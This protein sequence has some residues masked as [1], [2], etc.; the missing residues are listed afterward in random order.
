[1]ADK[2]PSTTPRIAISFG[3]GSAGSNTAKNTNTSK[4]KPPSSLGKRSRSSALGH[5]SDS[6]SDDGFHRNGRHE[7]ITEFG[8]DKPEK[9][10]A[11]ELVIDKQQNRDWKSELRAKRGG[12]KNLLP[13]EVQAQRRGEDI[14]AKTEPADSEN[15]IQWGLSVRKRKPSEEAPSE[16]TP[17]SPGR[18]GSSGDNSG[19]NRNDV[20]DRAPK[21]DEDQEAIDALMGKKRKDADTHTIPRSETDAYKDDVKERVG[22]NSTLE[23]YDAIPD[24]EFGAALLRGMGWDGKLRGPKLKAS[25]ERRQNQLGLGAKKLKDAE[26][27]GQWDH[28]GRKKDSRPPRLADYRRE[29][30]KK[31]AERRE[32]R[33]EGYRE[34]RDRDHRR[35]DRRDDR[36]Y[37]DYDRR[38]KDSH[39]DRGHHSSRR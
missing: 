25:E 2:T 20:S 19:T 23:D 14:G 31:K 24:G 3:S 5:H 36:R 7:K 11:K 15:K 1:M 13:P 18:N 28:G 29:E 8:G 16:S 17:P 26:D 12:G 32:R 27:L 39:R 35:D 22:V 30:E 37:D 34:E 33:G 4:S 38:H 21:Q 6:D 10:R 9:K